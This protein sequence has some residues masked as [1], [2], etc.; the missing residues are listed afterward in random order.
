MLEEK[1]YPRLIADIGGTNAR[2]AIETQPFQLTDILSLPCKQ[3]DSLTLAMQ[4]Y[5]HR[6]AIPMPPHVGVAIANPVTG[7]KIQM[8]NHHWH[9]SIKQMQ[10]QLGAET[11]LVVN[12]FQAQAL[13]LTQMQK[14][15]FHFLNGVA[16]PCPTP[17]Q[18]A[19]VIGPGTGL[20]VSALIPDAGGMMSAL[21]GEGGHVSF[22]PQDKFEQQLLAFALPLFD[23]HV[24]AER[25]L[26]GDGLPLLYQFLTAND[27]NAPKRQSPAEITQ[28]AL[29]EKDERCIAVLSR[30]CAILGSFCA[31]VA[32]TIGAT[33][34]VYLSGGI[35]PRFI[36]FLK[37]SDFRRCF[38]AKGRFSPYLQKIPVY[39]VTHPNPGL[40]GAAVALHQKK[41]S[42]SL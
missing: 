17:R 34:G 39:V 6:L 18:T 36:D 19:A 20:G 12:D 21:A 26:Q 7:D 2:F 24:S 37:Q 40:L 32:L 9:F 22:A 29:V 35:V 5:L 28:A 41:H 15:H 31:N 25:L 13:A 4:D 10:Q 42:V 14:Q 16:K 33:D 38:E 11:F 8:T 30:Y 1:S 23:G 3:Y 27:K